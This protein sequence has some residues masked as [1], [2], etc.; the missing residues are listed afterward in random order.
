MK[1][2]RAL[3]SSSL[4]GA[5]L[6]LAV[7]PSPAAAQA[8]LKVSFPS[9]K[10]SRTRYQ[11]NDPSAYMM[12]LPKVEGTGLEEAK[13]FRIS[14]TAAKD[15]L[16]NAIG[17]D[18]GERKWAEKP[19]GME[20]WLKLKGTAREASSVTLTGTVEAWIPS[21]D[22]ASEVK[23]EKFYPK[24]GKPIDAPALKDAKVRV[25]VVPRDRVNDGSIVLVG[26]IADM[27]RI[28]KVTVLRADGTVIEQAG[29]GSQ[30]DGDSKM[31][32]LGHREVIPP[33]ATLVLTLLTDKAVLSAPFETTIP[34]P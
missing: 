11:T 27:E 32:E 5:L 15:D 8:D 19:D 24:A 30:S 31:V 3:R 14:L 2:L 20:L 21:R 1:P 7:A 28:H 9:V 22:P 12:F 4:A 17:D 10:D 16:G 13:G 26:P 34:L 33:D 6:A 25:T 23:V 18:S 29:W